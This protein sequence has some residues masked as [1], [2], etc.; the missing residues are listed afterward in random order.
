MNGLQPCFETITN[1]ICLFDGELLDENDTVGVAG[2]GKK[3]SQHS[4]PPSRINLQLLGKF[5]GSAGSSCSETMSYVR[6]KGTISAIAFSRAPAVAG[7]ISQAVKS[8]LK[9]SLHLR[10][11]LLCEDILQVGSEKHASD[12][13]LIYELPPRV[14][15]PHESLPVTFNDYMFKDERT[16]DCA[17]RAQQLLGISH[18]DSSSIDTS[19]EHS[20]KLK[21]IENHQQSKE[22]K[23]ST[24]H[25]DSSSSLMANIGRFAPIASG[26]AIAL[27][28]SI[29]YLNMEDWFG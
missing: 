14:Y 5:E 13:Q 21:D 12:D 28:V 23:S 2:K 26:A 27:A 4:L 18:I 3:S 11:Q 20:A 17:E 15:I 9:K 6:I 24:T 25:T 8:D 22:V 10:C 7:D 1:A 29:T 19:V 16:E